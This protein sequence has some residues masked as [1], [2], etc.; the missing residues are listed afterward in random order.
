MAG[1]LECMR[2]RPRI[3][4][5]HNSSSHFPSVRLWS[6]PRHLAFLDVIG[7]V[8]P[9]AVT[10]ATLLKP[11]KSP[12]PR[13]NATHLTLGWSVRKRPRGDNATGEP[14]RCLPIFRRRMID[15]DFFGSVQALLHLS[16]YTFRGEGG[17]G[18]TSFYRVGWFVIGPVGACVSSLSFGF[19][20]GGIQLL[21]D[22][23]VVRLI[24]RRFVFHGKL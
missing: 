24:R 11:Y 7:W 13:H 18:R 1:P 15:C 21:V 6:A 14:V 20:C 23:G 19:P 3:G 5:E 16:R 2:R 8:R 10:V 9:S 22:G 12:G 4:V 17:G